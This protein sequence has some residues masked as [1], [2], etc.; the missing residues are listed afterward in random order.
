[1]SP[2][3]LSPCQSLYQLPLT[4]SP[5]DLTVMFIV[6]PEPYDEA[7]LPAPPIWNSSNEPKSK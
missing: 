3:V 2:I 5:P 1:L 7:S 4:R 6:A